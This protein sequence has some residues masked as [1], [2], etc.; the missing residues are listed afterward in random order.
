MVDLRKL[1]KTDIEITPIGLG[2]M[3]MAEHGAAAAVY[4]TP[5]ANA[6]VKAA[7]SGGVNWVDTAEMYGHGESE[8]SLAAG[9]R[10]AGVRP[11]DVVVATK[12]APLGRRAGNIPRTIGNRIEAL[13]GF[14]IDLYQIH[15]PWSF[16]ST[17]SEM[18]EMAKLLRANKIR[19]VGV[20][21]F[22]ARQ[23][24]RASAALRAEGIELASNQVQIS[25]LHRNIE[26]NGVLDT[27]R[28]LGVTL[29]AYS[30]LRSGMLTGRFHDNPQ[31]LRD[32]SW[33][34]R[35]MF[36]RLGNADRTRPLIDELGK[37]GESY[38]VTRAQVALNWVINFYGP[39]VVAIPGASKPKQ[40][41]EAAAAQD[42][43]L[44]DKE[45]S[46]LDELSR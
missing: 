44:T 45:L 11:G 23:M 16:S 27:A 43:R 4:P 20:S 37:I 13:Q 22:N 21:N 7:L 35:A 46:R 41:E 33:M 9:L 6:V 30:P 26:R 8:R 40:A 1:G 36:V 5:D 2:C 39:A 17:A 28:K 31:A 10:N 24:S 32:A 12:W 29:I 18:R 3:Q 19:S 14:P 38:G 42:F 34:R 15:Q 25:L